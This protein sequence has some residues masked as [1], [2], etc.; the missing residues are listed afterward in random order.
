MLFA[1][2]T[3]GFVS[4]GCSNDTV[5]GPSATPSTSGSDETTVDV[6]EKDFSLSVSPGSVSTHKVTF[7]I[8]NEGP[9]THEFVVFKTN[10]DPGALPLVSD[11]TAVNEDG[12]GVKHIDER[13]DIANGA[14]A[15]LSLTL[16]PGKYVLVCNLPT[17][18]KLGMR[19][20]FTVSS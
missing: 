6:A 16:D 8:S 20:G 9:T 2:L 5:A 4:S 14:T 19:A 12:A 15:T 18:Y 3:L 1:V 7:N 10:L 17:H 11:G 13:E